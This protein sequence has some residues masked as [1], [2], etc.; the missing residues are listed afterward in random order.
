MD[1]A[2]IEKDGLLKRK[3]WLDDFEYREAE[4]L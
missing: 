2:C 3:S 1:L 4:A